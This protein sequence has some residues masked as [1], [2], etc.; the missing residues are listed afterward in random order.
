MLVLEKQANDPDK[1]DYM[2]KLSSW[3]RKANYGL[4]IKPELDDFQKIIEKDVEE[5]ILCVMT[6]GLK[7]IILFKS[8]I[9]NK[10]QQSNHF[11]SVYFRSILHIL[12]I[13][14]FT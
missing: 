4:V 7:G 2:D 6:N 9:Q 12:L 5:K 3:N 1:A 11:P 14:S 10:I 13:Q 8:N